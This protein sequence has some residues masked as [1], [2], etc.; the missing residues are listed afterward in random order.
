MKNR[1]FDLIVYGATSFVGQILTRYLFEHI[2]VGGKVNWAIAGRSEKKLSVLKSSLGS[3]A[4]SL[5]VIVADASDEVALTTMC[6][7]AR[8]IASTVGPYALYGEPLVKACAENGT[9]YCDL[10]GEA[11]WIKAMILKYSDA[12]KASGAR[13]VSCCGFDS[14]PS[15]LGVHFLQSQGKQRF[16]KYFDNIKL[17]V[18][19]MKG[20]ASGGTL[21]SMIEAVKAAKS[22]PKLRK[23]MNNP[24]ILCPENKELCHPQ[25]SIKGP[26]FDMDFQRWSAPFIMEAINARVVLRSNMIL[27]T[28]YGD[29]FLYREQMMTGQGIKGRLS[30][31]GLTAGLGFFALSVIITPLRKFL[32]RFVLPKPGEGPSP[33]AQLAGYFDVSLLGKNTNQNSLTIRVTG[34]RDPGYGCTAKMLAQAVLC[35]AYDFEDEDPMGGF[36]TPATAMGDRLIKRLSEHAGMTFTVD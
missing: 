1:S 18:N 26:V 13:I 22:D 3:N 29:D 19:T 10:C 27:D 7:S 33:A 28:P 4:D 31:F 34:D 30:A 25:V 5:S 23:E 20:G 11:Y 6:Q 24:Y 2:G 35:L 14:I 15:D 21:A 17:A 12:A 32:Q 36:L 9:D 8:V 16:G